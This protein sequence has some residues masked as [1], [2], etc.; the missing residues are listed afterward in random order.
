MKEKIKALIEKYKD[1]T[2]DWVSVQGDYV[3]I[4]CSTKEHKLPY[5]AL[6]ILNKFPKV[7]S[8]HFTGGWV[9]HYYS[10]E[11]L[12]WGGFKVKEHKK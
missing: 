4:S 2:V 12:K 9:E 8:V 1:T 10:R 7:K 3:I 6:K 5:I 11:T